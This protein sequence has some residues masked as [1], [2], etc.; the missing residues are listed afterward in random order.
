MSDIPTEWQAALGGTHLT[1]FS[2]GQQIAIVGRASVGP[3]AFSFNLADM[4]SYPAATSTINTTLLFD[5][6]LDDWLGKEAGD[7]FTT[8]AGQLWSV[9]S[10]AAYGF[11]IPGTDTY[12]VIGNDAGFES[13]IGYKIRSNGFDPIDI[14]D[15][16]NTYHLFDVNDMVKVKNGEMAKEDVLPY[17]WGELTVPFQDYNSFNAL[18]GAVY[19]PATGTLYM[20]L[21]NADDLQNAFTDI[22]LILAYTLDGIQ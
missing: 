1:G 12:M 8:S 15:V 13:G 18:S 7:V 5:Y 16:R 6:D 10:T 20:A 17:S 3:S 14:N 19:D 11:I 9:Q 22:P 21:I 4:L 2:A